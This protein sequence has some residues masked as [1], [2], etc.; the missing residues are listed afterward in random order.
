M[1]C[2]RGCL[3]GLP[4]DRQLAARSTLPHPHTN[5]HLTAA[6]PVASVR[7]EA[8]LLVDSAQP[9]VFD[10]PDTHTLKH[11][12]DSPAEIQEELPVPPLGDGTGR[13]P[14]SHPQGDVLPYLVMTRSG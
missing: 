14:G 12:A 13:R 2:L 6:P 8:I 10:E 4:R 9:D 3:P 1:R 5:A 7:E 11:R